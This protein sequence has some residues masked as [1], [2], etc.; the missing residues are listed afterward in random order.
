MSNRH[1]VLQNALSIPDE[2]NQTEE[3][4]RFGF[5]GRKGL[6]RI[7]LSWVVFLKL[8]QGSMK[9]ELQRLIDKAIVNHGPSAQR[10]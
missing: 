5:M 6:F 8:A 3:A 2:E 7:R 10:S 4:L 9:S 1:F